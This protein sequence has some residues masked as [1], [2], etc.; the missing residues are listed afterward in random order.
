MGRQKGKKKKKRQKRKDEWTKV[1]E[2]KDKAG[3]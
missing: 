2:Q 1:K 3:E